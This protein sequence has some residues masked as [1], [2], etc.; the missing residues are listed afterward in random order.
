MRQILAFA[1]LSVL[2]ACVAPS[3]PPPRPAPPAPAPAPAPVPAPA[4]PPAAV[5]SDWRDWPLAPGGWSYRQDA[6]GSVALFGR[7]GDA[8]FT[9]R[10]DRSRRQLHLTRRGATG[11]TMTVRTSSTARSLSAGAGTDGASVSLPASDPLV[12]A[13]GYSRGRFIVETPGM[14]PLVVPAWA[15]VLRVAEDCR[16]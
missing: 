3:A 6:R 1:S 12:D 10:C 15:E 16:G 5:S 11:G 2:A 9:L 14:A 4:P 13:M 8:A 7:D